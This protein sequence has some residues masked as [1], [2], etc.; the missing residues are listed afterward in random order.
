MGLY[1]SSEEIKKIIDKRNEHYQYELKNRQRY[2]DNALKASPPNPSYI[3]QRRDEVKNLKMSHE[4]YLND[5]QRE[6]E[7]AKKW[8]AREKER[9]QK[10]KQREKEREQKEREQKA[11]EKEQRDRERENQMREKEQKAREKERE[12]NER[13]RKTREKERE[14]NERERK[15][16]EGERTRTQNE[17][18]N[19]HTGPGGKLIAAALN[20]SKNVPSTQGSSSNNLEDSTHHTGPGGKLIAAALNSTKNAPSPQDSS[21]T[22]LSSRARVLLGAVISGEKTAQDALQE[23]VKTEAG[24]VAENLT[25]TLLGKIIKK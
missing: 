6:L 2:L 24:R 5:L 9:E 16:R 13:E 22:N 25:K 8:E 1:R 18:S 19:H 20:A 14:L 15:A 21:S 10:A 7:Q 3:Q 17:E 11:R 4:R 23:V 12:L